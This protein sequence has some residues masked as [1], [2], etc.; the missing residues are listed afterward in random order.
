MPTPRTRTTLH[1]STPPDRLLP[2]LIG[3]QPVAFAVRRAGVLGR[4]RPGVRVALVPVGELRDGSV[5]GDVAND[6]LV[7]QS[8]TRRGAV[9]RLPVDVASLCRTLGVTHRG[10]GALLRAALR[11]VFDALYEER[12]V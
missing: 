9:T 12:R 4:R 3:R 6:W 1:W 11:A 7:W 2:S 10:D 8:V 5:L